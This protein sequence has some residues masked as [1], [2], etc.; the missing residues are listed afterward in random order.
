M[1]VENE[2]VRLWQYDPA[3]PVN[4]RFRDAQHLAQGKPLKWA[5][6][7]DPLV[8]DCGEYLRTLNA[9]TTSRERV[10]ARARWPL[11]RATCDFAEENTLRRFEVQAR[12]LGGQSDRRIAARCGVRPKLV[13][14]FERLFFSVRHCLQATDYLIV[15]AVGPSRWEGFKNDQLAEFW[16]WC[17]LAGGVVA[18][19]FMVDRLRDVLRPGEKPTLL[20]Y[21]DRRVSLPVQGFVAAHAL[22]LD[23]Q[24]AGVWAECQAR[25]SQAKAKGDDGAYV[26]ERDTQRRVL[27]RLAC[28]HLRGKPLPIRPL[29]MATKST[30]TKDGER[31]SRPSANAQTRRAPTLGDVETMLAEIGIKPR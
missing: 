13:G 4:F 16:S 12:L 2:A 24:T 18:V 8:R 19:D 27:I 6:P 28:A 30:T 15:Q 7:G 22:P 23:G 20:G 21:F 9:A 31:T 26:L 29:A 14:Y 3:C 5:E 10:A 11:I 1:D 17:A 25:L